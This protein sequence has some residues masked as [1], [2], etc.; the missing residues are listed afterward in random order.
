MSARDLCSVRRIHALREGTR[1]APHGRMN[2]G[3][4]LSK[5]YTAYATDTARA[6]VRWEGCKAREKWEAT[7]SRSATR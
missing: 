3:M 6:R 1:R 7:H 5:R 4:P 2:A